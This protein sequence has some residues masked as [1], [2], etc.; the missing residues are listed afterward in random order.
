MNETGEKKVKLAPRN[1]HVFVELKG[2]QVN[3]L[4]KMKKQKPQQGDFVYN[5]QPS[6]S[7]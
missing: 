2:D 4:I 5:L 6:K 1:H 3:L 7:K